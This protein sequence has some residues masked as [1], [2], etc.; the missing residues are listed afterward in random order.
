MIAPVLHAERLRFCSR[1][2]VLF[3]AAW[4]LYDFS[5]AGAAERAFPRVKQDSR[6]SHI[7]VSGF[8]LADNGADAF[9]ALP[10]L[11]VQAVQLRNAADKDTRR[12]RQCFS[13]LAH[14][15]L[16]DVR[17]AEDD[18]ERLFLFLRLI[19]C[20]RGRADLRFS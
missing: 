6:A 20:Q 2:A 14:P 3:I 11:R 12:V 9:V 16:R 15:L 13:N 5:A 4:Q 18:V 7:A 8:F 10:V 17:R 1:P 19:R